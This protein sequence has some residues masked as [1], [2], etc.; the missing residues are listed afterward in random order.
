MERHGNHRGRSLRLELR[1][2]GRRG[3]QVWQLVPARHKFAL[4]CAAALMA[5]TSA[6]NT[7]IP[8]LL[9]SLVD[10]LQRIPPDAQHAANDLF[11]TA[12]TFLT[13]IGSV[14]LLREAINVV[15]RYFVENTC[16]RIDRDMTVRV[17]G[18]LL[19]VDLGH[20]THEKVGALHGRISRSVEGFVRFLRLFFLDFFP[21]ILTGVFAL[22]ATVSKQP[23]LGV[24]MAGVIPA[25]VALTVWQLVSQKG[26]RLKLLRTREEMDGTVVEQL[27]GL[28]YVRAS[29]SVK[30]EVK[31]VARTA[32]RRRAREIRHHFQMSLF[33]CA[34]ALNEGLFHILV[35][36]LAIYLALHGQIEYGYI[37]TFSMLFLNVMTPVSEVHRI[38][39]EGHESSLRVGDLLDILA[40][41]ADSSFDTPPGRTPAL[42]APGPIIRV[43]DL[44]V[45]YA[46]ADGGRRQA[47]QGV[48]LVINRG[49]RIGIAGRSGSGK[50]TWL[51][52]LLRLTHPCGGRVWLGGVPLEKVS[53]EAIAA[54]A[55]YV[56]QNPFVFSG[57][58]EENIAYG[59]EGAT[60]QAVRRAA[61]LACI[62]DEILAMP[63][64]Y[65][66]PVAERGGNLSGGSG[67][68]WRWPGCS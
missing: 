1:L 5:V 11:R 34:K 57:A 20:L 53:R 32:E 12:L 65:A 62:H 59:V 18:H 13:L 3:R 30:Q 58:I 7:T 60:P 8:L 48:S 16:T 68:G 22:L 15:R 29:N 42:D 17:V 47:L 67:S 14:Y 43:E 10:H 23:Y 52:G 27:A 25:S 56:G 2:I 51:K 36:G 61:E 6:A 45:E 9:G 19:K 44:H 38:I 50:S 39:D 31:R 35:L 63:G 37:L 4:G 54:L 46:T 26:V 64:G 28:D 55:G 66:A 41:P 21:A 24:V 40:T 33:G 49:E